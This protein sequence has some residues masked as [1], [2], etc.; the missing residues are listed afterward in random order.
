M[1][2]LYHFWSSTCSRRVRL[3]LA[4]KGLEWESR[5]IDLAVK[6]DHHSPEYLEINP[7]GQVP[8]LDHDGRIV[9]ESNVI[10]E[11]LDDAFPEV[12]L[13][14]ADPYLRARMRVLMDKFEHV[15]HRN[16]N[17]I[18]FN[19]RF[20]PRIEKFPPE[21]REAIINKVPNPER[22]AE[23]LRRM[24][25][26]VTEDD[27]AI[28]E[29]RLATVLD[30]M[31]AL[32][33]DGPWLVGDDFSLADMSIAPFIERFQANGLDRLVDWTARPALGDWWARLQARPCFAEA[34]AFTDPDAA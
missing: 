31:E 1:L 22:R 19:R 3:C 16:I 2:T 5:H 23:L 24:R 13:R 29:A 28:A 4:E 26:G 17:L 27:E 10:L 34:Y 12:G 21:E 33:A 11:Y 14:P 20:R 25:M 8:T 30:E 9:L 32:L 15:V 6:H 7:N 18:S